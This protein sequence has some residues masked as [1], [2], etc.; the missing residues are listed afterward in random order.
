MTFEGNQKYYEEEKKF[1]DDQG[2]NQ[3]RMN[4]TTIKQDDFFYKIR[5]I[6]K[7]EKQY[8]IEIPRT[9]RKYKVQ[10]KID[11]ELGFIGLP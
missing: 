5:E 10:F 1:G 11:S 6:K 2:Y 9:N 8:I 4:P 3:H 7:D